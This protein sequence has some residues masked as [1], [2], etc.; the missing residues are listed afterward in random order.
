VISPDSVE[1]LEAK[2]ADLRDVAEKREEDVEPVKLRAEETAKAVDDAKVSY[3]LSAMHAVTTKA[4]AKE[5]T[6][7]GRRITQYAEAKALMEV[8]GEAVTEAEVAHATAMA[9]AA[10]AQGSLDAALAEIATCERDIA[11]HRDTVDVATLDTSEKLIDTVVLFAGLVA[12]LDAVRRNAP[13]CA[14]V[15]SILNLL[16]GLEERFHRIPNS[17]QFEAVRSW[18]D[19][20]DQPGASH[21]YPRAI[22][23]FQLVA[24]VLASP[25]ASDARRAEFRDEIARIRRN[26]TYG[27]ACREKERADIAFDKARAEKGA[28]DAAAFRADKAKQLAAGTWKPPPPPA[29]WQPSPTN[30]GAPVP[31]GVPARP[32]LLAP[33]STVKST[34]IDTRGIF[35]AVDSVLDHFRPKLVAS[36]ASPVSAA[37]ALE[38]LD[39]WIDVPSPG[40]HPAPVPPEMG[41]VAGDPFATR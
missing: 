28:A 2:L 30:P 19:P 41:P 34:P 3:A 10:T 7:D 15:H 21:A 12:D 20:V 1:A 24:L 32:H 25:V 33:G 31:P 36:T 27:D 11:N 18:S 4:A 39:S 23:L 13:L 22:Q 14:S 8:L 5:N 29:A 9:A 38:A 16:S 35:G 40:I 17:L 6:K 37:R 26:R